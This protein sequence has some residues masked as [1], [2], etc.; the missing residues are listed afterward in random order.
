M[1]SMHYLT[2]AYALVWIGLGIYMI[3]LNRRIQ[4]VHG[5]IVEL[6]ER[7]DRAGRA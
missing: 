4:R 3:Q 5:D 2:L 7:M 1:T 6:R